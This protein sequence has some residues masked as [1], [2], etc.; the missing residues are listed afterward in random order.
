MFFYE[1]IYVKVNI[2]MKNLTDKYSNL[3]PDQI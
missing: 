1:I 2:T 3:N